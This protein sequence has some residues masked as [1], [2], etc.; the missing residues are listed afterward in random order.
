MPSIRALKDNQPVTAVNDGET[1]A[2]ECTVERVHPADNLTF[3][4]MSGDTAVSA[5][6][7]AG[8]VTGN[9]SDGTV[10][11]SQ[12]SRVTFSRSYSTTETGLTCKVCQSHRCNRSAIL[13]VTVARATH[14]T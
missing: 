13:A 7:A 4:I 1:L 8:V 11:V 10:T 9:N 6:R 14:G 3:Q 12:I 5:K 2:V